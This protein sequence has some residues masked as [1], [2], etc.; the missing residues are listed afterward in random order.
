M[1]LTICCLESS[2][3]YEHVLAYQRG[4]QRGRR[5]NCQA[6][7]LAERGMCLAVFSSGP[8]LGQ[9]GAAVADVSLLYIYIYIYIYIYTHSRL[10]AQD[11]G[12]PPP[13]GLAPPQ[14]R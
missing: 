2:L 6:E 8:A 3:M 7:G 10:S 1:L 9:F 13:R 11:I 14:Q 12:R 5:E 4:R